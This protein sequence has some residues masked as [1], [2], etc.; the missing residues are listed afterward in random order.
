MHALPHNAA[1][2]SCQQYHTL[3]GITEA[4]VAHRDLKFL[5][6]DLA[7]RLREVVRFD[8]LALVRHD[9]ENN[10][11]HRHVFDHAEPLPAEPPSAFAVDGG[12][13]RGLK[14]LASYPAGSWGPPQ[15]DELARGCEGGWRRP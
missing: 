1:L 7:S 3:L 15:A 14:D 9:A 6:H 5:L 10:L 2:A 4:I 11:M 8:S 13:S 12:A